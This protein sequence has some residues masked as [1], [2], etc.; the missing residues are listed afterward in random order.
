MSVIAWSLTGES[1]VLSLPPR[2][3]GKFAL[4]VSW[5]QMA[6]VL[7]GFDFVITEK[8]GASFPVAPLMYPNNQYLKAHVTEPKLIAHS[9]SHELYLIQKCRVKW[10]KGTLECTCLPLKSYD[11]LRVRLIE[12]IRAKQNLFMA[13]SFCAINTTA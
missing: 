13:C 11:K 10:S 4:L 1:D 2:K 8:N 12:W 3:H 9:H 6:V 7:P 5:P